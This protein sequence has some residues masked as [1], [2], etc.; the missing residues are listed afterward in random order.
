MKIAPARFQSP[1]RGGHLRGTGADLIVQVTKKFQSPSRGGHLRG[2]TTSS[3]CRRRFRLVSV[4]FTRGTPPWQS[5]PGTR[6]D[7][8]RQ[9]QSPSRGGHLRGGHEGENNTAIRSWFQSPSRGGHLRG[10]RKLTGNFPDYQVSVPFTRGTPP[11]PL[12]KSYSRIGFYA[13]LFADSTQIAFLLKTAANPRG[14]V[15]HTS[16]Q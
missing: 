3:R 12:H 6:I 5:L 13:L 10:V 14:L 11:W 9:F 2:G 1:S 16:A 4:P 8:Y 7:R 15:Y